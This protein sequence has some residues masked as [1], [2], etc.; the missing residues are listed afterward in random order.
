MGYVSDVQENTVLG[1]GT[2]SRLGGL[3][4]SNMEITGYYEN[5]AEPDAALFA[6]LGSTTKGVVSISPDTSLEGDTAFSMLF[7]QANYNLFGAIGEI[8]PFSSSLQ[9]S[10][11]LVRGILGAVGVK[12]ANGNTTSGFTLPAVGANDLLIGAAHIIHNSGTTPTI[13]VKIVSD[14]DGTFGAGSTDVI[15]FAQVTTSSSFQRITNAATITDT[16]Y[17]VEW[18][19]GGTLPNYKIFVVVGV[20]PYIA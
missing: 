7:N 14:D 4:D 9:G 18:T 19:V 5:A 15:T 1:V 12:T 17:R 2:R 16:D 6:E 13:D 10:G 8:A 11:P 3:L 20:V